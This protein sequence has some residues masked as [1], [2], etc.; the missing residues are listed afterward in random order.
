MLA[1]VTSV[2]L[3][4]SVAPALMR[5]TLQP[6]R[7]THPALLIEPELYQVCYDHRLLRS[8]ICMLSSAL[9]QFSKYSQGMAFYDVDME[10]KREELERDLQ[11]QRAELDAERQALKF[12]RMELEQAIQEIKDLK[13][14]NEGY[15]EA[16][17]K[18]SAI[19]A[20][21]STTPEVTISY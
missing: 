21:L 7:A 8:D 17:E 4:F 1:C 10:A 13:L 14:S 6:V 9:N 18:I 3:S 15:Q 19:T 16:M 5:L 11:K 2:G 20:T 12:M